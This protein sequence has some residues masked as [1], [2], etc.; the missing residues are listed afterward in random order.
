MLTFT[1]S[2]APTR[3]RTAD[4]L[5][6]H[7]A[8]KPDVARLLI[9]SNRLPVTVS[10]C[11]SRLDICPSSGGLATGLI[12]P[13]ERAGG[14]WFG[15]PGCTDIANNVCPDQMASAFSSRRIVPIWLDETEVHEFYDNVSSGVL[16]PVFHDRLDRVPL[17]T[18]HWDVYEHV[19][20]RFADTIAAAYQPGDVIWVHDFHLLRLPALLRERLPNARIGFFLH[21]PFPAA[22]V[23]ET[24]P[25]RRQLLAG[26]LGADVIGFHTDRYVENF[27][28]T[29]T[30]MLGVRASEDGM[31]RVA[32]RHVRIGAFPMGIDAAEFDALARS[33]AVESATNTL[34]ATTPQLLVGVDRL[35][36]S[37]GIPRRLLAFEKLLSD[38]P[39]L[40]NRIRLV[41][42][43]VPSRHRVR[44][45]QRLR[46]EVEQLVGRVNG[47]F[48]TPTWTPIHYIHAGVSP[49]TLVALYRAA[50][51]MLVTPVRDGM[52]LVAKEF[53]A[54]RFD[55]DGVLILSE[56][57]G[58]ARELTAAVQIHPY[59]VAGLADAMYAALTMSDVERRRRMKR[60]RDCVLTHDV[61]AWAAGFLSALTS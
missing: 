1:E 36:Y 15:W 26:M 29:V 6:S 12:G 41:Q 27:T 49:E 42:V 17:R 4:E 46:R 55:C 7:R 45:Y 14:L 33:R 16:W 2:G 50:T 31:L 47:S 43:A 34:R 13:H 22:D 53:V 51:A 35:D 20:T 40:R 25:P 61:H 24:L 60:M 30:R 59:D 19:N 23:F 52:N 10:V 48:G 57:A 54:S 44:A 28:G 3:L 8:D 39:E 58:A 56:F 21:I 32:N 5:A 11:G 38:H 9:A 18:P 37:K